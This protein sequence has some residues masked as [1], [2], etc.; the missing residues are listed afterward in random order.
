VKTTRIFGILI[1]LLGALT[2]LIPIWI[3]PACEKLIETAAGGTVPM[4]C[5]WSGKAEIGIGAL[6]LC[7]GIL[8]VS[9]RSPHTRIGVSLMSALSAFLGI[10]VP[11]FLVGGCAMKTMTC[12]ISTFPAIYALCAL[13][14]ALNAAN[15]LWLKKQ[16]KANGT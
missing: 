11:A 12:R 4:K 1:S 14:A 5:H 2:A 15:L 3:F 7:S 8:L 6:I 16:V 13:T 10:A 9:L